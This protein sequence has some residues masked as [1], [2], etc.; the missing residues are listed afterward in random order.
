MKNR[1]KGFNNASGVI[2]TPPKAPT[3]P[4]GYAQKTYTYLNGK[5]RTICVPLPKGIVYSDKKSNQIKM[6]NKVYAFANFRNAEGELT[7]RLQMPQASI[8]GT[9][10]GAI[11][12]HFIGRNAKSGVATK[13]NAYNGAAYG[14]LIGALIE[15][16]RSV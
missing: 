10:V 5:T 8:V 6:Q 7:G 15:G 16:Y 3:C 2:P 12:G 14:L 1:N 13:L 11:A 9:A 4:E